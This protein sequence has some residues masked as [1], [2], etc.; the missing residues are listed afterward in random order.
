MS[1][2]QDRVWQNAELSRTYLEGVRGAIP[3][4]AEQLKVMLRVIRTARPK[5]DSFLD[6]G[7][8]DGILGRS[9]LSQYPEASGIFLDFSE[10]MLSAARANAVSSAARLEY[11]LQDYGQPKW[12]DSVRH[13]APFDVIVS[14][15][16]IHHQPD[17]RKQE[18]YREIFELLKPGAVFLNLDHVSSP[19]PWIE[20]IFDEIFVDAL[21]QYQ[22]AN[23]SRQTREEIAHEFYHRPDKV[24]N[25]LAPV[26]LQCDWLRRLG[27]GQVDC[28]FKLFE[29]ALFGGL[30]PISK[31]SQVAGS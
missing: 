28:Y 25:I 13:R 3:L 17:L 23:G 15:F 26:E 24:A 29:L 1:T 8:G 21:Y 9:I 16:S 31:P 30:R 19:S 2:K 10:S 22:Q 11:L 7:C 6:L 20:G 27:F 4:A 12:V 5:V 18:L 14:G